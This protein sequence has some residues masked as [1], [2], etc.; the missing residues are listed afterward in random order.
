MADD[1]PP[2]HPPPDPTEEPTPADPPIAPPQAPQP[3]SSSPQRD[4]GGPA[5]TPSGRLLRDPIVM[6]SSL[7]VLYPGPPLPLPGTTVTAPRVEGTLFPPIPPLDLQPQFLTED[8]FPV[9]LSG[10]TGAVNQVTPPLAAGGDPPLPHPAISDYISPFRSVSPPHP[11]EQEFPSRH[12]PTFLLSSAFA[13]PDPEPA[14]VA[15][16][17]PFQA[18]VHHPQVR[19]RGTPVSPTFGRGPPPPAAGDVGASTAVEAVRD[20]FDHNEYLELGEGFPEEAKLPHDV[21]PGPL[22]MVAGFQAHIVGKGNA[23]DRDSMAQLIRHA[24]PVRGIKMFQI[25]C[26]LHAWYRDW[27]REHG[28][29]PVATQKDFAF[30]LIESDWYEDKLA[31]VLFMQEVLI[32]KRHISLDDLPRF[33]AMFQGGHV[34]VYKVCDH[35]ADKV[36]CY[37]ARQGSP[38]PA[39]SDAMVDALF[40][41]AAAEDLWQARAGLS[42]LGQQAN[43]V[44]LHERLMRAVKI[45]MER[46]EEEAKSTAGT[47]LRSISD[48]D[49]VVVIDYLTSP[50]NIE[51]TSVIALQKATSR[52]T[53][54]QKDHF[55]TLRRDVCAQRRR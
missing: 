42:A 13:Q 26:E 33:E 44:L 55:R 10:G 12:G 8:E 23:E 11:L 49:A 46:P 31:A 7:P 35:F 52:L 28:A 5:A 30:I 16:P 50:A 9:L 2:A 53:K 32:S 47:V 4:D 1:K 37:L 43:N 19:D 41:W 24:I 38:D 22:E 18:Y 34:R 21:G 29:V 14:P 20:S 25:R 48:V 45:M 54:Q 6:D 17:T 27:M 15:A 40:R 39:N 3:T 51:H 36:L